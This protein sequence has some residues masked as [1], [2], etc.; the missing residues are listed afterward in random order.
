M[1][2]SR[3]AGRVASSLPS[4][5]GEVFFASPEQLLRRPVD[6]RSDLFALGLVL[7]ELLTGQHLFWL[8]DVDLRELGTEMAALSPESMELLCEA[9]GGLNV[10]FDSAAGSSSPGDEASRRLRVRAGVGLRS[11]RRNRSTG[12]CRYRLRL[13]SGGSG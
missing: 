6:H 12:R 11:R 1:A 4:V 13:G 9:V 2:T 3:L 10:Q 5:K 8:S 7:L